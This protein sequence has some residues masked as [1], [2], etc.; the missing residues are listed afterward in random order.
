MPCSHPLGVVVRCRAGLIVFA[1]ESV[2]ISKEQE[3]AEM[4]PVNTATRIPTKAG[5]AGT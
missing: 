4:L 5:L 3:A 2:L 1:Q